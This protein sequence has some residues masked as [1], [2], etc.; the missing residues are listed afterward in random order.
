[1]VLLWSVPV[2]A[3]VAAAV[4]LL[5]AVGALET[6]TRELRTQLERFGAVRAA[7]ADVR[8]ETRRLRR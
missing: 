2:L 4:A 1:M 6:T 7:V 3:V 8:A 5:V